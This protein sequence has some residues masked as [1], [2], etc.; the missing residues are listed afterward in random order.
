MVRVRGSEAVF[1][2]NIKCLMYIYNYLV[3]AESR[4]VTRGIIIV[5][6]QWTLVIWLVQTELEFS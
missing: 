4:A 3:E 2:L 6:Q 5:L 1:F